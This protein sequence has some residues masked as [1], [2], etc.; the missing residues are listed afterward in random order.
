MSLAAQLGYLGLEVS[1]LGAWRR[2]VSDALGL[3][4]GA[5]RPD[6]ASGGCRF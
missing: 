1:N 2:F 3:E 6:G 5:P 4:M